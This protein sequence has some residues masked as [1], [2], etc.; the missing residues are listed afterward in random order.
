MRWAILM[1]LLLASTAQAAERLLL[2]CHHCQIEQIKNLVRP[3]CP[4]PPTQFA[5][6]DAAGANLILLDCQAGEPAEVT[7]LESAVSQQQSFED[8]VSLS[9]QVA[10]RL[11][12]SF[13]VDAD[14]AYRGLEEIERFPDSFESNL[15][16]SLMRHS[17]I[18][19]LMAE[20]ADQAQLVCDDFELAP[21]TRRLSVVPAWE[22]QVRLPS[23]SSVIMRVEVVTYGRFSMI[24][25]QLTGEAYGPVPGGVGFATRRLH[26]SRTKS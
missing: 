4:E 23:R 21:L 19:A 10:W 1:V 20:L 2:N 13:T 9:R 18:G 6:L 14:F 24:E 3:L 16:N 22:L 26:L 7:V 11:G 17:Q 5:V 12:D 25:A 15:T 8:Y